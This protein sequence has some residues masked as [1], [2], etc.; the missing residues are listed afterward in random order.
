VPTD[1]HHVRNGLVAVVLALGALAL[2]VLQVPTTGGITPEPAPVSE[3]V[4]WHERSSAFPPRVVPA[5]P[6]AEAVTAEPAP[7]TTSTA[8]PSTTTS[9]PPTTAA[10]ATRPERIRA[11]VDFPFEQVAP[12]WQISFEVDG[13]SGV[14]GFADQDALVIHVYV[15]DDTSDDVLAFTLAHE[16]AHALDEL[17]LTPEEQTEFRSLRGIPQTLDWLWSWDGGSAGDFSMPAGDFAESF[18]V[19]ATGQT[20]EWASNLGA[21]PGPDVQQ[22]VLEMAQQL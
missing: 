19:A 21:P 2:A 13:P 10:P 18:A 11:L 12:S 20:S 17:H 5:S 6:T 3:L 7:T 1:L 9:T 16:M 14:L 4:R 15:R 8:A 22:R